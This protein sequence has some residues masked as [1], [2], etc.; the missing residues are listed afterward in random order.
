PI[1]STKRRGCRWALAASR[2]YQIAAA[3]ALRDA[4]LLPDLD[5]GRVG[6]V[7]VACQFV[8]R[9]AVAQRN[10]EQVV[11]G[12]HGVDGLATCARL[13]GR[14]RTC[15]SVAGAGDGQLLPKRQPIRVGEVAGGNDG[16]NRDAMSL[17]N[18]EERIALLDGIGRRA[19]AG[20]R[21]LR[22]LG[23]GRLGRSRG[24]L[25]GGRRGGLRTRLGI[26]TFTGHLLADGRC[27]GLR[28]DSVNRG[29]LRRRS[30]LPRNFCS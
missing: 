24:F 11:S 16:V 21:R 13:C 30:D 8:D 19:L 20:G 2:V 3:L 10:A 7:V 28:A 14:R 22:R 5:R 23:Y 12:L 6:D 18:A 9:Q 1:V 26:F 17:C 4:D 15:T 29:E 27:G 25:L